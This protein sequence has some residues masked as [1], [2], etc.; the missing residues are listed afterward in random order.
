MAQR[1]GKNTRTT[2][3]GGA[4]TQSGAQNAA[5]TGLMASKSISLVIHSDFSEG[6]G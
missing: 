4:Q 6:V 5:Q 2:L 1:Q 3:S